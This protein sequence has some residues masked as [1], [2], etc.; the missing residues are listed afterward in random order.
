MASGSVL[1]LRFSSA[2]I[3]FAMFRSMPADRRL[4]DSDFRYFRTFCGCLVPGTSL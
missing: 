4:M 3:Q 1:P 2:L